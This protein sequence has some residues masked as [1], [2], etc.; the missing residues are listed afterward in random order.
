LLIVEPV[1]IAPLEARWAAVKARAL[2]IAA[3]AEKATGR[4]HAKLRADLQ[5]CLLDWIA[6]LSSVR[7][8]NPACGS[9]NFLYLALRRMMDLW[10]EARIF[11]AQHGLLTFLDKQV[12]PSQ[13]YGLETNVY[14]QELA[15]VVV[16]IGYLQ[17]LNQNSVGWPTEPILRKL[18]NIQERDAILNYVEGEPVEA[19][20]PEVD[21]I[22][23]NPPFLGDAV[24]RLKVP[25]GA[26]WIVGRVSDTGYRMLKLHPR[27]FWI[28]VDIRRALA[29]DKRTKDI[30]QFEQRGKSMEFCDLGQIYVPIP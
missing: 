13:L 9:G 26:I 4:Q 2:E 16:W 6:A 24:A 7:I 25:F 27:E 10:H 11:A 29:N 19:E 23:G 22:I 14:A 28:D 1:V 3:D 8:L 17:W 18:D 5:E 20:W 12:H 21:F 15:S 30:L